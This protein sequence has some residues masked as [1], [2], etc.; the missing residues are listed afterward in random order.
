MGLNGTFKQSK[1]S[2]LIPGRINKELLPI[3][4]LDFKKQK[5]VDSPDNRLCLVKAVT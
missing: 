4:A 1:L 3:T 5:G 2:T